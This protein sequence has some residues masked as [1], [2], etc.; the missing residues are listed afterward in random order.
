MRVTNRGIENCNS[1]LPIRRIV[2]AIFAM[3][4]IQKAQ[5]LN[6]Q[7]PPPF[8]SGCG[9]LASPTPSP[10]SPRPGAHGNHRARS[11]VGEQHARRRLGG[12]DPDVVGADGGV[13]AHRGPVPPGER[14]VPQ[15]QEEGP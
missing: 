2:M 7:S 14:R 13:E 8:P 4:G 11:D 12:A 1:N 6:I 9:R 15:L 5:K 10:R 3:A